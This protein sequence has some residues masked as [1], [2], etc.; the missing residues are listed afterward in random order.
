MIIFVLPNDGPN[1]PL[2]VAEGQRNIL[3]VV[4][5]DDQHVSL[6]ASKSLRLRYA[7]QCALTKVA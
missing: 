2:I 6:Y 1:L 7:H 3:R 5:Q 4:P